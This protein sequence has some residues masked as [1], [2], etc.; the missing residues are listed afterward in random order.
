M[1]TTNLRTRISA[2]FLSILMSTAV[3]GATLLSMAPAQP[4]KMQVIALEPV[5]VTATAIN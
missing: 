2:F 5:T 3:M 1:N 4:S